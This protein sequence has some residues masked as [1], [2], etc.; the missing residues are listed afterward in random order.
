MVN[1]TDFVKNIFHVSSPIHTIFVRLDSIDNSPSD[2]ASMS[3][4]VYTVSK[5]QWGANSCFLGLIS[6]N[7]YY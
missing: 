7:Y 1:D 6:L 3:P 5:W 4:A 2:V